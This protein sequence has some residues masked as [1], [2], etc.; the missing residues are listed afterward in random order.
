[1]SADLP[2]LLLLALKPLLLPRHVR[3]HYSET[4]QEA[5]WQQLGFWSEWFLSQ[6]IKLVKMFHLVHKPLTTPSFL[7]LCIAFSLLFLFF[8]F[9][10]SYL[11]PPSFPLSLPFSLCLSLIP[12]LCPMLLGEWA[13]VVPILHA[14]SSLCLSVSLSFFFTLF[15][16]LQT[17]L[18]LSDAFSQT[19]QLVFHGCS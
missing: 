7:L 10:N 16:S 14:G 9:L 15:Y 2:H 18:K 1:M 3:L 8:F 19:L 11:L 17:P 6:T 4:R 5:S 13:H 12:I